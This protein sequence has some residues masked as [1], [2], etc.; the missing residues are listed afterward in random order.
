MKIDSRAVNGITIFDMN[1][2][3][4]LGEDTLAF[5]SAIGSLVAEGRKMILLNLHDVPYIDSSGL[6]ELVAAFTRVRD[7]GG[8][9][10]LLNLSPKI[11][12]LLEITRLYTLFDVQDDETAAIKSFSVDA[13]SFDPR[14]P[15]PAPNGHKP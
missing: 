12:T 5:R 8:E 15:S 11:R 6:G 4:T 10:K 2:R 14:H 3:I 13:T 1:G 9:L 7:S